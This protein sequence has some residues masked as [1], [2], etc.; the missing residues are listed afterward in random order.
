M[1]K[2]SYDYQSGVAGARSNPQTGRAMAPQLSMPGADGVAVT[3]KF[4][5][6]NGNEIIDRKVG[7]RFTDKMVDLARR[8]AGTAAYHGL[9]PVWEVPT[10]ERAGVAN[11]FLKFAK[12]ST[13]QVRV[14]I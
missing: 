4:D 6:V 9:Q 14:A 8:Q 13:I 5:G 3:A 11:R 7:L 2:E 10:A 1:P 12:M